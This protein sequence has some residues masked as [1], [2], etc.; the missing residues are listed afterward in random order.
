[1]DVKAMDRFAL[2]ISQFVTETEIPQKTIAPKDSPFQTATAKLMDLL[3][4]E[5]NSQSRPW[6]TGPRPAWG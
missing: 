3:G 2:S 1:M 5:N 6:K 4:K